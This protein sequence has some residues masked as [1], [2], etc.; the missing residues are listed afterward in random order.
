[1][2]K[3]ICTAA[4]VLILITAG[5]SSRVPDRT[6]LEQA[7]FDAA[8]EPAA[9][10]VDVTAA[11]GVAFNYRY[12]FR[13]P[14]NRIAAAQEAH[15]QACE[16]LGLDRCRIIG[17][18]YRLVNQ[19]D[20]QAMLA[21]RLDPRIART[22]GKQATEMVTRA[23]GMLVDQEITG[24]DVGTQIK[25]ATT[26][27]GRLRADLARIES[28]LAGM[29]VKDP[30]RGELVARA[31]EIRTQIRSL[32]QARDEDEEALA[33]TPMVFNYGSGSVVPGFDVRSP[34]RDALQ[35]AADNFVDGFATILVLLIT[36]IPWALL[37]GIVFWVYRWTRR[38]WGWSWGDSG[39]GRESA[40][41]A[42]KAEPPDTA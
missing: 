7:T 32:G 26:N 17:M 37:A 31:D 1:M 33:G 6:S 10:G 16:G 35:N 24:E 23:D 38:R 40:P 9:P 5:C 15:A 3:L 19:S 14:S 4:A 11:P 36:L 29:P 34:M 13:L 39:Y 22:F 2:R 21:L 28:E 41:M 8:E 18:R 20:I 25:A 42:A 27:E 30:R 12:A